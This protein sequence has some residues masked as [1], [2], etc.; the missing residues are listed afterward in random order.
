MDKL[1]APTQQRAALRPPTITFVESIPV[2][3]TQ[4]TLYS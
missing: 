2:C 3:I 4:Y 1:K